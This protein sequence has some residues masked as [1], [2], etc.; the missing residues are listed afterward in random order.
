MAS[1]DVLAETLKESNRDQ[2]KHIPDKLTAISCQVVPAD[3]LGEEL[4]A[5]SSDEIEDMAR[6]EHE[7]WVRERLA[8]GWHPASAEDVETK[9]SPY[10]VGWGELSEYSRDLDRDTVRAI[11]RFLGEVGLAVVRRPGPDGS[12][13]GPGG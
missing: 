7:R 3:G 11:P 5:F 6:V 10:L 9:H 13:A 2:A 4:R 1:W 8:G 12:P